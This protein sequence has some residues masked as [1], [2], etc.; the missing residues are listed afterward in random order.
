MTGRPRLA[1]G[2][3]GK[4]RYRAV[5][6]GWQAIANHRDTDGRVRQYARSGETKTAARAE[7]RKHIAEHA[8]V[9]ARIHGGT[10]VAELAEEYFR[11]LEDL[12][13][14]GDCSPGTLRLYRGHWDN[15][16]EPALGGLRITEADVQCI[17]QFLIDLRSR[18]SATLARSVRAVLSGMFGIAT[19]YKAVP[20]NPVRDVSRI[21]G[22]G[23]KDAVALEPAEAMDLWQ[24]LV[25]L[26]KMPGEMAW[27]KNRR[28]RPTRI[29]PYLPDLVLWMLG[30]SERVGQAI[31]VH[32]PWV[33]LD[34][35]T[36]KLG[37]NI[38]R[39]KGEGLRLNWGTTKTRDRVLDL[40]EPVAAM[41]LLRRE[42][43]HSRLGL[44]FPDSFGG[45]RDPYNTSRDLRRAFDMAGYQW[46]TSH[47]F[48]KTVATVLD[49]AGLS[50][51]NV[52][53]QL[54]H[55]R[56]SLTQDRYMARRARNPRAKAA[57]EAMLS[58]EPAARVVALDRPTEA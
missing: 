11:R 37:P 55:A 18:R 9:A 53:D 48:R 17:D 58:T 40:P 5:P 10:P 34:T 50:A 12:V 4:V 42:R 2:E 8:P 28:Y 13:A 51:R 31:A 36:A 15:H 6:A 23:S 44:V 57:I 46:V 41:L 39:V 33:D 54:G 22:D 49:D 16:G 43:S 35:A 29:D 7:L 20:A 1:V 30:T 38:I 3:T 24:K 14:E 32:W 45:M 26:S 25:T 56:P 47:T 21:R 19:R 52:A 27:T